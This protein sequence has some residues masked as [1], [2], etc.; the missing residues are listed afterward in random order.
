VKR[1]HFAQ[2]GDQRKAAGN[3]GYRPLRAFLE[4]GGGEPMLAIIRSPEI[5]LGTTC[6]KYLQQCECWVVTKVKRP[7]PRAPPATASK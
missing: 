1:Q 6:E 4:H 7:D 2:C 3:E 5:C